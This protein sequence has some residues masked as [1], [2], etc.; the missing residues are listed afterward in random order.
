MKFGSSSS[1]TRRSGTLRAASSK[2]ASG[3]SAWWRPSRQWATRRMRAELAAAVS[4]QPHPR[5]LDMLL[6]TGEHV[7]VVLVAMAVRPRPRGRLPSQARRRGSSPT[8]CTRGEDPRGPLRCVWSRHSIGDRSSSSPASRASHGTRWTAT[9][10]HGGTD[11]TAVAL[12]AALGASCEIYSDVPGVFAANPR[13]VPEARKLDVVSYE[14]MLEMAASGAKVLMLRA[15]G[16]ARKPRCP[17]ACPLHVLERI[18]HL[19]RGGRR[20]EQPIVSAVFRR[21]RGPVRP[22]RGLPDRPGVAATIFEAVAAE[23]VGVDL[24]SRASGTSRRSSRSRY[25]RRTSRRRGGRSTKPSSRSDPSKSTRS[26]T[27]GRS[28]S[29]AP[30]CGRTG[31]R[32]KDVPHARGTGDQ[33]RLIS[34]SPIKVV[35]D[36]GERRRA[37]GSRAPRRV[38]TR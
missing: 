13:L 34:T 9:L 15:V 23:H 1:R 4:P 10:G 18:G 30:A 8:R 38:S 21:G 35:P 25:R 22:L 16:L 20:M 32:G 36:H 28:L 12:A 19:G 29:S 37:C 11:A 24:S 27:S 26:R 7:A 5:E 3:A 14:E 2:R 17:S 31:S 33:R 6:S